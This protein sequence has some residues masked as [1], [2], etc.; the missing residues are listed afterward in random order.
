M[1]HCIDLLKRYGIRGYYLGLSM[2]LLK[3]GPYIGITFWCNEKLK[4][5]LGYEK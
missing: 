5:L 4:R 1:K 3:T 2:T